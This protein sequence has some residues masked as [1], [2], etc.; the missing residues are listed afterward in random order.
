MYDQ[1]EE[2]REWSR[3]NRAL[4]LL[5]GMIVGGAA[6]PP[7]VKAATLLMEVVNGRIDAMLPG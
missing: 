3:I 6:P 1:E 5:E 7:V 4:G 2:M